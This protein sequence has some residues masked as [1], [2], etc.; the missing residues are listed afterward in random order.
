MSERNNNSSEGQPGRPASLALHTHWLPLN[1][2]SAQIF[3][4]DQ[5]GGEEIRVE[6]VPLSLTF[7]GMSLF[8]LTDWL[9]SSSELFELKGGRAEEPANWLLVP[10]AVCLRVPVS[11]SPPRPLS[12]LPSW[13]GLLLQALPTAEVPRSSPASL[14]C[15][16]TQVVPLFLL[17]L[18]AVP[19]KIAADW[20]PA[21]WLF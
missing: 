20:E 10:M 19:W 21:T 11:T 17:A 15:L 18:G 4:Y 16:L 7:E 3:C 8:C 6:H 13:P 14:R 5:E 2:K 1:R 9:L 12:L